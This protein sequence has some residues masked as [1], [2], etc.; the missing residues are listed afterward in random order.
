MTYAEAIQF[1]Y[2]LRWFGAKFGEG[3]DELHFQVIG[4]ITDID[5]LKLL[6]ELFAEVLNHL[7]A[8]GSAY[9]DDPEVE[10]K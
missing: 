6:Y 4:V 3:I 2:S 10:L 9:E 1:L 5:R 8:I 7:C